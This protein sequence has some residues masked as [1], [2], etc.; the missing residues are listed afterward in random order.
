LYS[1]MPAASMTSSRAGYVGYVPS[2]CD[3]LNA[4]LDDFSDS[5]DAYNRWV[6]TC[7]PTY[8]TIHLIT[9]IVEY[10]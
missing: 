10:C 9:Y 5:H 4:V 3:H 2:A 1:S 8:G 6:P 7:Y